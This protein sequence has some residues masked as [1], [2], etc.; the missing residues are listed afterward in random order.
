MRITIVTNYAVIAY[1]IETEMTKHEV[2]EALDNGTVLFDLKT[3]GTAL[4]NAMNAVSVEIKD[5]PLSK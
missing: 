1:D 4:I 5:T 2:A 3:G